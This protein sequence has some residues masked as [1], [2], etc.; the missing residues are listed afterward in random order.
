MDFDEG[1]GTTAAD[2]SGNGNT[3]Y[4]EGATWTPSGRAGSALS[5]N[6]VNGYLSIPDSTSLDFDKSQGTIEMWI[7]PTNPSD[8][9][10]QILMID[11]QGSYDWTMEF[12]IQ[13]DGDLFFYPWVD[14]GS[15]SNYNL[16]TNPLQA[17]E[18]NHVAVTWQYSTR[19]VKTYVNGT[20]HVYAIENVPAYWTSLAQTSDWHIGGSPVKGEYFQGTIDGLKVYDRAL[21]STEIQQNYSGGPCHKADTSCGGC[22]DINE[23]V[24]FIDDWKQ[25]LSGIT[26]VE[27]MEGIM[28]YNT[29]Q[30]CLDF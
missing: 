3:G 8:G 21:S 10:Y 9:E 14:D 13:G 7:K 29:G 20:E 17:G 24:L 4:L 25:G 30:G 28:L 12:N 23:I 11:D 27:V 6:G 16:V 15:W 5:F 19:E 1:S 26:L 2:S 22:V 18:W